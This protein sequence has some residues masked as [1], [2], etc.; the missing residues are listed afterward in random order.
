[1]RRII[2]LASLAT[3]LVALPVTHVL[4]AP[5]KGKGKKFVSAC[6]IQKNTKRGRLVSLPG[7]VAQRLED[8]GLVCLKFKPLG[9]NECQAFCKGQTK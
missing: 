3:F 7:P 9:G 4:A 8:R 5:K 6:V 2:V 1:M